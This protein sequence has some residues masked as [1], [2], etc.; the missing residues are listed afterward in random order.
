LYIFFVLFWIVCFLF[1]L[2]RYADLL[3]QYREP[4]LPE[5]EPVLLD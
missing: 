1:F 2:P 3:R 5:A 4:V